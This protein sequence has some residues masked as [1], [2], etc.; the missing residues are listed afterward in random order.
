MA[1]N[2]TLNPGT[3]GD[4]IAT[5]DIGGVK[6]QLVKIEFGADNVATPVDAT[7]RLPVAD[8]HSQ[9][10]TDAQLRAAAVPVSLASQPLPT[11]AATEATLSALNANTPA[12]GQKTMANS[13]P[14]VI[15]SDQSTIP[16]NQSGVTNSGSIAV[17]N[18]LVALS[19]N[20]A[21]GWGVDLRGTW[22]ATVTFQGT[23]DGTNWFNIAVIP[24]GGG[25]SVATATTATANGAWWGNANGCQQ[26]RVTATAYTSGSITVV[27]RAM[28]AAGVASV[29]VTGA[30]TTPVNISSGTN[31]IGDVG[32]QY[33]T[34]TTG[35][36]TI[37][38]ILSPAT[39]AAQ[40]IKA[41]GGRLISI[42]AT[43]SNASSTRWLKIFNL[44]IGSIT[45]GTTAALVEV[46]IPPNQQ[47]YLQVEGG[48]AFSTGISIMVTGGQGLTNNTAIT[49]GDVT[50]FTLHS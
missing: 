30:T 31:A 21:N 48:A 10:L 17:L 4:V 29:L 12:V 15:A 46:A 42:A 11:G 5:D 25:T 34:S 47:F 3:G 6:H 18:G 1:D 43:N 27:L 14:V 22:S 24:A 32:I 41:S 44:L 2:T 28:Q 33:R 8:Q 39:P 20:G 50:G 37:T 13:S 36:A 16:V 38:N 49:L 7:N 9:P 23:I 35:A 26:V 19:L 40:T 45:P